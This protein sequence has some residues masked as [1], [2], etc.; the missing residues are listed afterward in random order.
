MHSYESHYEEARSLAIIVSDL[1]EEIALVH[2][3]IKRREQA[4]T[5]GLILNQYLDRKR[6]FKQALNVH[7]AG[8]GLM[9]VD[10]D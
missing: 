3:V 5:T 8:L 2:E 9:I 4:G 1:I 10:K 6:E 7:L